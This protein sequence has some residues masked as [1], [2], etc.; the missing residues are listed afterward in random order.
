MLGLGDLKRTVER[1]KIGL[2]LRQLIAYKT[3][4][5]IDDPTSHLHVSDVGAWNDWRFLLFYRIS[6]VQKEG[7]RTR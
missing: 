2:R 1:L 7:T 3:E 5:V 6:S 4:M